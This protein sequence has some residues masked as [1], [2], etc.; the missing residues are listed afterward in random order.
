MKKLVVLA[1]ALISFVGFSQQISDKQK[2]EMGK[3]L[4]KRSSQHL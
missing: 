3:L 4:M 1:L 2:E